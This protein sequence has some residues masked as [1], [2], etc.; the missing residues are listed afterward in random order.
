MDDQRIVKVREI[1]KGVE[2]VEKEDTRDLDRRQARREHKGREQ[3]TKAFVQVL[4]LK[5]WNFR[6][7]ASGI[8]DIG[9]IHLA[10]ARNALVSQRLFNKIDFGSP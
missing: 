9:L 3:G 1:E 8:V 6:N 7:H 4:S 2:L 10:M 5:M